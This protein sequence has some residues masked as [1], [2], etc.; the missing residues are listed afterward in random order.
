MMK[1]DNEDEDIGGEQQWRCWKRTIM[2]MLELWSIKRK[3]KVT[4]QKL[5]ENDNAPKKTS[6]ALVKVE[7]EED[8]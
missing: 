1:N 6:Y 4:A 7:G 2:K 3:R 8:E 5:K